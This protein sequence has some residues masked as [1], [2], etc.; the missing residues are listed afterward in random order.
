M[1][2]DVSTLTSVTLTDMTQ[3][4]ISALYVVIQEI[5]GKRNGDTAK[6][7]VIT[8]EERSLGYDILRQLEATIE[9][10]DI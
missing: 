9:A 5:L 7:S 1:R 10:D 2:I 8:K 6:T 3:S 4:E